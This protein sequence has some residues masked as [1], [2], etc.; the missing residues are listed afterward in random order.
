MKSSGEQGT[1]VKQTLAIKGAY[2]RVLHEHGHKVKSYHGNNSRFDSSEFQ[3]SQK[4]AKQSISYCGVGSH[5]QNGITE[6]MNKHLTH[7]ARTSLL[8]TK[9]KWPSIITSALWP[10]CIKATEEQH[11][12]LD[13]DTERWS[14][15]E[16]LLG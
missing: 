1:T 7:S 4:K 2:E 10:I 13:V 14:Q 12:R 9:C 15:L 3:A 5:D 8:H 11:N 6:S 16:R